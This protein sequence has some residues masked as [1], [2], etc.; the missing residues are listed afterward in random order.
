MAVFCAGFLRLAPTEDFLEQ[1][2]VL[3]ERDF[4]RA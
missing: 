3:K 1:I 4:S 2:F